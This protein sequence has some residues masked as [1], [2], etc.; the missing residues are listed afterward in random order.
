[1]IPELVVEQI[2]TKYSHL[3]PFLN[4]RSRR[5]WAA[6]EASAL[7]YGGIVAI[8]RATGLSQNTIRSGLRELETAATTQPDL[9]R[10]RKLGAGRKR[11]E[12]REPEILE[13]MWINWSNPVAVENRHVPCVGRAK[14]SINL[15]VQCLSKDI[16][17]V[18]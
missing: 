16:Q 1:M 6:T 17:S 9:N 4:E 5:L 3:Q 10:I 14:A 7:G 8:Q 15:P 12:H 18:R 13:A 11:L 2:E